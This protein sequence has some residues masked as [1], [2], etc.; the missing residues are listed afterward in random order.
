MLQSIADLHPDMTENLLISILYLND[1]HNII[2]I[3]IFLR[4]H[5]QKSSVSIV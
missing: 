2:I 1:I 4:K 5:S 3:R